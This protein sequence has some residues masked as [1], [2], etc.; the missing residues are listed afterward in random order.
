MNHNGM[1]RDPMTTNSE[2]TGRLVE[3]QILKYGRVQ[4]FDPNDLSLQKGDRVLVESEQGV[5]FG[6]VCSDPRLSHASQKPSR[7]VIRVANAQDLEKFGRNAELEREVYAFCYMR[8]KERSLPMCL[9]SVEC[10]FDEHKI[11]VYFTADGRVDF[12]EL[13]KDLVQKFRT[14]IEMRQIG[15]RH[16]AKMVGGLGTCGRHLCCTS[17]LGGFA[18]VS[19]KMAKE[20]NLSLNPSKIS[21]MCGR[22]MCCLAY[23]FD[24]YEKAKKDLPKV[25]KKVNTTYG[26]AK[27]IRQNIFRERMTILL[28]SGE[29][30][31]ISYEEIV[32]E[33][34]S[35]E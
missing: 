28:E 25:G 1:F 23:E 27:V 31:E 8:I 20:Q 13:V 14:R 11:M 17:F 19:I 16:Q 6:V 29:E 33:Q 30:K 21:G 12:R 15:V 34:P 32:R 9:V 7:K 10:L 35:R 4:S 3:V 18:P 22:L 2:D 26:M 24:H 5:S